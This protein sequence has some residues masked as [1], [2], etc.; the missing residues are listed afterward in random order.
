MKNAIQRFGKFLSA[1]VMPN[2]GAI[3]LFCSIDTSSC[4]TGSFG[5]NVPSL[6]VSLYHLPSIYIPNV[7]F[8]SGL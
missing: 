7:C 5:S 8:S 1:M 3:R 2:I 4:E 6:A